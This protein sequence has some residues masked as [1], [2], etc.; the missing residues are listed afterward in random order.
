MSDLKM[1]YSVTTICSS[2]ILGITPHILTHRSPCGWQRR[3][4][5]G[6]PALVAVVESYC[7]VGRLA[8]HRVLRNSPVE[9]HPLNCGPVV[10]KPPRRIRR[11]RVQL[12]ATVIRSCA[13]Q[14]VVDVVV[15]LGRQSPARKNGDDIYN[16]INHNNTIN[17]HA[18]QNHRTVFL[19][20][21]AL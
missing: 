14:V 19:I 8:S 9:L 20:A 17:A 1:V 21:D 4:Q 13:F 2:L 11:G 12:E 6:Q 5:Y 3:F 10:R 7:Q 18:R 16:H 15:F